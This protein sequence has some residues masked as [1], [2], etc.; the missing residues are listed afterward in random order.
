MPKYAKKG[1]KKRV[2]HNKMRK[3]LGKKRAKISKARRTRRI[4]ITPELKFIDGGGTD[5]RFGLNNQGALLQAPG[6]YLADV[7]SN[8]SLGTGYN[9]QIG[10]VHV[11][12]GYDFNFQITEQTGCHHNNKISIEIVR[13]SQPLL[14]VYTPGDALDPVQDMYEAA[15]FVRYGTGGVT[16]CIGVDSDRIL[17]TK[18]RF[19]VL[20]RKVYKFPMDHYVNQTSRIATF[21]MKVKHTEVRRYIQGTT[22][23]PNASFFILI[24]SDGG[25]SG[26]TTGTLANVA[27]NAASSGYFANYDVRYKFKDA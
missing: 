27:Q 24:R 22:S 13:D 7:T 14:N 4:S 6:Y 12:L 5:C 15:R 17:S 10:N 2:S 20:A 9:N 11:M 26:A 16:N 3:T 18:Q 25:N 8:P 21:K 1:G 19:K 23:C